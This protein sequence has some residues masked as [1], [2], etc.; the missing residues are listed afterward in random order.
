MPA[1]MSTRDPI[2]SE[3]F[4][5]IGATRMTMIVMGRNAAPVWTGE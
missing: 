1:V 4:P 2:R 3:A 5:A